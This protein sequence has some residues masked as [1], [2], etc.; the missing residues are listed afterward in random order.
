MILY[1]DSSA[2][3]KLFVEETGSDA[4]RRSVEKASTLATA[5]IA[6]AEVRAALARLHLERRLT[7]PGFRHLKDELEATWAQLSPVEIGDRLVRSAG[8]LAE[9]HLLR[10]FDAV[11]LAAALEIGARA[12]VSFAC[13]DLRLVR[14]ARREGLNIAPA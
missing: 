1:L 5:R 8:W 6:Y 10:G 9:R 3:V 7:G 11:H 13:F 14:A 4:T 2:L 12:D